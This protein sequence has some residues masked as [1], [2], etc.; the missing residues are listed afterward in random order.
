MFFGHQLA[1]RKFDRT[2]TRSF[3]AQTF[4]GILF[5]I[6]KEQLAP[7]YL[8]PQS[9]LENLSKYAWVAPN[10]SV[11]FIGHALKPGPHANTFIN[12]QMFRHP[13][14]VKVPKPKGIY[15]IF[16]TGGST[17]FGF[18]SPSDATT[19]SGYLQELLNQGKETDSL[20]FEVINAANC[21][22]A[23]S[24][25]R[26]WI[27]HHLNKFEPDL[28]LSFSGANDAHWGI[29]GR[30]VNWLRSYTDEFFWELL[31]LAYQ[32][33]NE[34]LI[35][36]VKVSNE[37]IG[38]D[39]VAQRLFHNLLLSKTSAN[40]AESK[41]IFLLQPILQVTEKEL[42]E[43]EKKLSKR[44]FFGEGT[45]SY[46]R[47]VYKKI[48]DRLENDASDLTFIDLSSTFDSLDSQTEVFLDSYHF[49]DRGNKYIAEKLYQELQL[50]L[51]ELKQ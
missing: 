20:R 11:P 26:A 34:E 46:F 41:Y 4:E 31:Q 48:K 37:R 29:Q 47:S 28:I 43:R 13:T 5:D 42:S 12:Q 22:W 16:L 10:T 6:P 45:T 19:L 36:T 15:R 32:V 39:I 9:A 23:S 35:D 49:G 24:H 8:D 38:E 33:Q 3:R 25:E 44:E 51:P 27:S 1:L 18:G 14:E 7:A 50:K 30:D 2:L 17:A 40:L 21:A